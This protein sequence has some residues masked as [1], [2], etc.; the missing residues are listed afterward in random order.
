V[1]ARWAALLVAA[2][3]LLAPVLLLPPQDLVVQA[4]VA[5]LGLE[6][7]EVWEVRAE[8]VV[9]RHLSPHARMHA[10]WPLSD[11][12]TRRQDV[13]KTRT[14]RKRLRAHPHPLSMCTPPRSHPRTHAHA[15]H[16]PAQTC[17][18]TYVCTYQE[19]EQEGMVQAPIV[20]LLQARHLRARAE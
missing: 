12:I 20:H 18:H 1:A 6:V 16:E 13:K 8:A 17:V 3:A 2:S 5:A 10:C 11:T 7:R 4:W 15:D 9:L 19:E 14:M